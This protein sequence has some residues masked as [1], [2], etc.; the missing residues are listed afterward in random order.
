MFD[1]WPRS[2]E[3]QNGVDVPGE[4][5]E[6]L[7]ECLVVLQSLPLEIERG[8]AILRHLGAIP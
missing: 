8:L 4:M 2:L 5:L 7:G 1:S 6:V 3:L